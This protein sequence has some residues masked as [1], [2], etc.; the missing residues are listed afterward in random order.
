MHSPTDPVTISPEKIPVATDNETPNNAVAPKDD[1][2]YS[3]TSLQAEPSGPL[4]S[5]RFALNEPDVPSI[6]PVPST[7]VKSK[8]TSNANVETPSASQG[9]GGLDAGIMGLLPKP[10]TPSIN[11]TLYAKDEQS[12]CDSLQNPTPLPEGLTVASLKG[13]LNGKKIKYGKHC[14]RIVN[15]ALLTNL[16]LP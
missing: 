9:Q 10:F 1:V 11:R 5:T 6:S 14:L 13:R 12:T 8:G 4:S 3:S 16:L 7:P 2:V 15:T